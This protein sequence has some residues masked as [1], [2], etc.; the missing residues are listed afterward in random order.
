MHTEEALYLESKMTFFQ[1]IALLLLGGFASWMAYRHFNRKKNN[2]TL[3]P[4]SPTPPLGP[5]SLARLDAQRRALARHQGLFAT[6]QATPP[7]HPAGLQLPPGPRVLARAKAE[8]RRRQQSAD[9][10]G[11]GHSNSG[12]GK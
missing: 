10:G 6:M 7:K 3:R 1:I 11:G 8:R 4:P 12:D 2:P 9:D 5:E